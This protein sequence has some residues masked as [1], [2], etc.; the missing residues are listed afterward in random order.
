M[1][2]TPFDPCLQPRI[3][4]RTPRKVNGTRQI[5]EILVREESCLFSRKS[6]YSSF[7]IVHNIDCKKIRRDVKIDESYRVGPGRPQCVKSARESGS[8]CTCF[9]RLRNLKILILSAS[10]FCVQRYCPS[11]KAT[12]E[13]RQGHFLSH[14]SPDPALLCYLPLE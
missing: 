6:I 1:Y 13:H 3:A 8:A 4:M 7:P 10:K 5:L 2:S 9:Y 12:S 14:T 11:K